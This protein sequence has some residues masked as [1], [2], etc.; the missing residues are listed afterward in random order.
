M[1]CIYKAYIWPKKEIIFKEGKLFKVLLV[2]KWCNAQEKDKWDFRMMGQRKPWSYRML[3]NREPNCQLFG[4]SIIILFRNPEKV[5]V[6]V[7]FWSIRFSTKLYAEIHFSRNKSHLLFK[8]MS[9][10]KLLYLWRLQIQTG[11]L[12]AGVDM[13]RISV[14]ISRFTI[15]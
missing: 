4:W 3:I 13:L 11:L 10:W 5:Q 14:L 12:C 9:M 8:W 15:I 7:I 6:T 1:F 2:E